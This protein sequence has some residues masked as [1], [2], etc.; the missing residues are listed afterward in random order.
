MRNKAVV[1]I[2]LFLLV[3]ASCEDVEKLLT[4]SVNHQVTVR[5]EST[6][7]LNI[8]I[9][10]VTPDVATNSSQTF[11]NNNTAASHVKDIRLEKIDLTVSNPS[12][13]T[14]SFLKSIKLYI[15]TDQGNEIELASQ[16][17]IP[18]TATTVTLTPTKEKLD[19]YV[20]ASSYKLRTS[21]V[22]REALTQPVDIKSDLKFKVT[23]A[24]L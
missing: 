4:F 21:V 9:D 19:T 5:I 6:S 8:P 23:A 10:I 18:A 1:S 12:G 7:P 24:P 14:F 16:D 13:K 3:F 2:G 22:T 15:S 17:N 20:K 11:Q